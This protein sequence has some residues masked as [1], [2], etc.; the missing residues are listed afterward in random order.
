MPA[1]SSSFVFLVGFLA[2]TFY[3]YKPQQNVRAMY[4]C[5]NGNDSWPDAWYSMIPST[6]NGDSQVF[7]VEM[8][9]KNMTSYKLRLVF[10]NK[11]WGDTAWKN[12]CLSALETL[13]AGPEYLSFKVL[14]YYIA[15]AVTIVK[16][17]I[18][19]KIVQRKLFPQSLQSQDG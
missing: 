10:D 6:I 11:T 16:L 5:F 18:L 3:V 4:I 2:N 13:A 14:L 9:N 8:S 12:I 1:I 19:T 17:K 15:L 7:K